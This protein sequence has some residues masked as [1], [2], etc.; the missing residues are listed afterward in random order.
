MNRNAVETLYLMEWNPEIVKW[1]GSVANAFKLTYVD[2]LTLDISL[3]FRHFRINAR[4]R[5]I[6]FQIGNPFS[7]INLLDPKPD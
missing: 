7:S 3:C 6:L 2:L 1:R 5:L 4:W